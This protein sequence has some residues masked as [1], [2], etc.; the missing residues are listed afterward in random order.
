V[1]RTLA[2]IL[3]DRDATGFV[4]RARELSALS[5]LFAPDGA[6]R[7]VHVHG[8]G[9]IGKSALLREIA[10]RGVAN[11]WT[12]CTIEG[13]ELTPS[14]EGLAAALAGVDEMRPLLLFDTYERVSGLD[15]LLRGEVLRGL[16]ADARVVF[17]GRR[18]PSSGWSEDGWETVTRTV[19]LGPLPDA[20]ARKLL[21]ACGV[22]ADRA[23]EV[24]AAAG[25]SPLALHLLASTNATR[26]SEPTG[27]E[28][29]SAVV[30]TLVRRLTDAELD[31][32][33]QDVLAVAALTRV[34]TLGLIRD[35]LPDLDSRSA[36]DWLS[37]R[38]F[39][40]PMSGGFALHDL[41]RRAVR[42]E[43]RHGD[44]E[45]E[46]V[47]RRRIADHL[48][49]RAVGGL[50]TLSIDLAHL[51][52]DPVLRWGYSWDGADRY[53]ADGLHPG[54]LDKLRA[55][56]G[57][58]GHGAWWALSE[59]VARAAPSRVA[60]VRDAHEAIAGF[61]VS[62]TPGNAPAIAW[63]HPQ[64]GP[65]LA[66]ARE[67]LRSD[68]AIVIQSAVDLSDDSS[69]RV[70][71]M[72][73]MIGILRSGLSNPRYAYLAI[74]PMTSEASAFSAA[75][76]AQHLP[77]LDVDLVAGQLQCHLLDYGPGGLLGMQ[78]DTV[79]RE[80][81]LEPSHQDPTMVSGAVREALQQ[82]HRPTDLAAS[83]LAGGADPAARASSVRAVLFRAIEE[84][85]GDTPD[86]RLLRAVITAGYISALTTHEQAADELNVSR[87]TYFRKL[88]IAT[89]RIC[90]HV[91]AAKA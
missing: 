70:Q 85:F 68:D 19:E 1:P 28:D 60:V 18:P 17:A 25:G 3:E 43:L 24:A 29:P 66:H 88:R 36:L 69:N 7:V 73:G 80:T 47:M 89:Q 30:R 81:G 16:S 72:L 84:A 75:V 46:R 82:F 67:V 58:A 21:E 12:S 9:G 2:D 38:S 42:A 23:P 32:H 91:A 59:P 53:H 31:P 74:N 57:D 90:D 41:V 50:L 49:S 39:A 13:R 8:P 37:S 62:V 61:T 27:G 22:P 79:Y 33:H 34:T 55:Q 54:D 11:G 45:R 64:L 20:D 15:G 40:E 56:M 26:R 10:R 52:D 4:G 71:A 5:D 51:I 83:P 44:P 78:R 48:H 76:G 63:S 65:W 35:V 77:A 86:E 87:A 14:P 6:I